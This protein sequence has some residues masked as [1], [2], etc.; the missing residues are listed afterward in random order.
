VSHADL[1]A[2]AQ[3]RAVELGLLGKRV[4]IDVGTHPRPLDW[5]LAPVAGRASLVLCQG[6]EN[7][8]KIAATERAT[9]ID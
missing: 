3:A 8:E 2:R 1:A 5:L 6:V 9:I 4:L 7:L